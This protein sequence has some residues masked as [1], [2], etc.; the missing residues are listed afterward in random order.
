MKVVLKMGGAALEDKDLVAQFCS[1]VAALARDGHQVLV[2]HGGGAALSRRLKELGIEPRFVNGL[3]VTDSTTRDVAVMVLGGL[4]NKQL[5]AAIG[6]TGQPAIGICG[7]D[8]HL[9]VARKKPL[10]EDHGFVGEIVSVNEEAI[11]HFWDKGAVPIVASLAQGADGEFY[12]VNADEM[13]SAIAAGCRADALIFLTDVAGVK[14]ASGE[15]VGRLGLKQ[16]EEL[17][18]EG[19]VSGGMLPKLA[20]SERALKA[21]V[22]SV[23]ILQAAKVELLTQMF[24][25]PLECGTELVAHV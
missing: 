23:R 14:N 22:A 12:N 3:R 2:V 17:R 4:L 16:I 1:A 13:A 11:E 9:C 18:G 7:S 8:L 25:A 10:T 24:E 6:A 20:A 19:T 5:A 21:G 15:V